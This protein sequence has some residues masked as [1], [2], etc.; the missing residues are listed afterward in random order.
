MAPPRKP[1][2]Q[3]L[4]SGQVDF[5][6][7]R[8]A[9]YNLTDGVPVDAVTIKPPKEYSKETKKAWNVTVPAL[10]QMKVLSETDLVNLGLMFNA[11]EEI[12][13]AKRAISEFEQAST[14]RAS[15][16]YINRRKKLNTWLLTSM[17]T[18]INYSS[19]YGM[20]PSDRTKLP[21]FGG[22]EKEEEEDPLDVI[23]G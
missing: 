18:F 5:R 2:R 17:Q 23:L 7:A 22:D 3:S 11:Y 13:S 9:K 4:L 20:T 12:V 21:M 15:D 19:R 1:A 16:E 14:N 8:F 10:L 6:P